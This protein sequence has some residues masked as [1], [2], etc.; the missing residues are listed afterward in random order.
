MNIKLR[1]IKQGIILVLGL[2]WSIGTAA[3]PRFQSEVG[4]FRYRDYELLINPAFVGA[5][6]SY[7]T[8]IGLHKQWTGSA[9]PLAETFQFHT[10]V[11]QSGGLGAWVHNEAYGPQHNTQFGAAY[12]HKIKVGSKSNLA[13]GLNLSLLLMNE[14]RVEGLNEADEMFD[15]PLSNQIGFNAGF[16]VYYFT[17]KYYA[18]LSVPQLLTNELLYEKK[19]GKLEN[20]FQFHQLQYYLTG[21][22]RFTLSE[23]IDFTPSAL[24]ALSSYTSLAYELMLTASYERRFEV[25]AGWSAHAQLQFTFGA[26][27]LKNLSLRYRYAH[28]LGNDYHQMGGSHFIVLSFGW[29]ERRGE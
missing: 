20:N 19:E 17:G 15:Q 22:Y 25:G 18:G 1:I 27:V 23:K 8:A 28:Q 14:R 7:Y 3:Q 26:I 29:G 24:L 6:N 2:G 11:A 16:G 12:A 4:N 10:P 13:F 5:A 9:S 21:G